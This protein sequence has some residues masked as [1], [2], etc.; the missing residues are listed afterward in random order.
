MQQSAKKALLIK[1]TM[2]DFTEINVSKNG[3][4]LKM[5]T[6]T[7]KLYKFYEL[8][9]K[10]QHKI[11]LKNRAIFLNDFNRFADNLIGFFVQKL[12]NVGFDVKQEDINY[13]GFGNQGDGLSFT[14]DNINTAAVL[15]YAEKHGYEKEVHYLC[16]M[17]RFDDVIASV[18]FIIRRTI[19]RY[20]HKY[21]VLIQYNTNETLLET[22]QTNYVE[23]KLYALI[24]QV[25]IDLCDTFYDMLEQQWK[26]IPSFNYLFDWFSTNDNNL[27]F[28]NGHRW[29]EV[30]E[31]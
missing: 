13:S 31:D 11:V 5:E 16:T 8:N 21:S 2:L 19:N 1:K 27:Y 26:K 9:K 17:P 7:V 10:A 3:G 24:E 23:D 12:K 20:V 14:C 25:R 30:G 6:R 18:D 29:I 22:P 15:A 28:A 4:N